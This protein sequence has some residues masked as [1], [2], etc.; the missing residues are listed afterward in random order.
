[1]EAPNSLQKQFLNKQPTVRKERKKMM[2]RVWAIEYYFQI[3]AGIKRSKE[4]LIPCPTSED[5]NNLLPLPENSGEH[6]FSKSMLLISPNETDIRFPD[7]AD[8]SQAFI[9]YSR[10][11]AC[12]YGIRYVSLALPNGQKNIDWNQRI[13]SFLLDCINRAME[14]QE[15]SHI[16]CWG[17]KP[18]SESRIEQLI[19]KYLDYQLANKTNSGKIPIIL[20]NLARRIA[21][22]KDGYSFASAVEKSV[23]PFKSLDSLR[24]CL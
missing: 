3:L 17:Y 2:N 6:L 7:D 14:A 9:E 8:V 15:F 13:R 11:R 22:L 1:M 24:I 4:N 12:Q 5:V 19:E 10:R 18:P 16:F 23:H 20:R 21:K